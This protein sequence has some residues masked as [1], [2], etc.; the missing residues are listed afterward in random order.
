VLGPGVKQAT[1]ALAEDHQHIGRKDPDGN[2]QTVLLG[3][4]P[5]GKFVC[6]LIGGRGSPASM[7]G[8]PRGAWLLESLAL[9]LPPPLPSWRKR[10]RVPLTAT[11]VIVKI[12]K[13]RVLMPQREAKAAGT[14]LAL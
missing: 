9:V 12:F 1:L 8:R 5:S 6:E 11:T 2:R 4:V 14:R 3:D 7:L 13:T 10:T